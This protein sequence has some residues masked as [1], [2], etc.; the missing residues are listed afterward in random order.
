MR[1]SEENE[2]RTYMAFEAVTRTLQT[3]YDQSIE[4][5]LGDSQR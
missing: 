4:R 3:Y 5:P 1:N 2:N